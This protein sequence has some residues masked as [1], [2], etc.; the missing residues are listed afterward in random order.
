MAISHRVLP[1]L[2]ARDVQRFWA[3]ILIRS[4]GCWEWQA[5]KLPAGYGSFYL[6][7]NKKLRTCLAHRLAYG[8]YYLTDPGPLCVCHTCDNPS[9]V[10]P[11]H[12]FLATHQKN[13]DDKVSKNR[14][15]RGDN[16]YA[17]THPERLS[18]GDR[19]YLRKHPE[20]MRGSNNNWAKL[21]EAQVLEIRRRFANE[22]ISKTEL[23]RQF[24][25]S[26]TNIGDIIRRRI[27]TH[28]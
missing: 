23:G 28:I 27:W 20:R 13:I 8:I 6:Y 16:H 18:R 12:L 10:N 11:F 22:K 4:N 9:C 3:S 2:I 21:T 17:K 5:K 15:Y 7:E 1:P 19:H 24:D 25:T 14:Q 26:R